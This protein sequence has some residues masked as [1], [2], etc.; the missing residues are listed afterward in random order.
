MSEHVMALFYQKQRYS[1]I[2]STTIYKND[3]TSCR[4]NWC[5]M[6]ASDWTVYIS[7]INHH[8]VHLPTRL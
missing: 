5:D 7:S 1:T 2:P 4:Y 8:N 3:Y 6:N